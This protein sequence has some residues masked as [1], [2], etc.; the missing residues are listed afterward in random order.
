MF[1]IEWIY[2]RKDARASSRRD[3]HTDTRNNNKDEVF[4]RIG[5]VGDIE[6][7]LFGATNS[8]VNVT[9]RRL[10]NTT[11]VG[12]GLPCDTFFPT[13]FPPFVY[14]LLRLLR[15]LLPIRK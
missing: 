1:V 7:E 8:Q 15:F 14:S 5:N 4:R 11:E 12:F 3:V 9:N 2:G 10:N 13:F 6:R